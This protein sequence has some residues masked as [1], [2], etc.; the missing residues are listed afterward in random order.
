MSAYRNRYPEKP[1]PLTPDILNM[2]ENQGVYANK[3]PSHAEQVPATP[4]LNLFDW[5]RW[6]GVRIAAFNMV[7]HG[8]VK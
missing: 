6:N 3:T 1:S 4:L 2:S 8:L 7:R 5:M